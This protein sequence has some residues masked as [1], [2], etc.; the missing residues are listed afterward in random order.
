MKFRVKV[1]TLLIAVTLFGCAEEDVTVCRNDPPGFLITNAIVIDG[2]G[3][4]G[5]SASVRIND[6]LIADIGDLSP[7]AGET[8]VDA[9][10]QALAPGFI[11]THSHADSAI[12]EHPDALAA[13][14]QGITTVVIGQG[15]LRWTQHHSNRGAW[16]GLS[17]RSDARRS[18]LH[19]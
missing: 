10:G 8:V 13:I 11:D 4:P 18:R 7:C 6:G 9:A 16:R 1:F 5:F 3:T 12:F 17:A 15:I 19:D 14:S 2:S